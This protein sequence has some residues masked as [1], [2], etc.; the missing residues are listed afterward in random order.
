MTPV[1]LD[2]SLKF[3]FLRMETIAVF[4]DNVELGYCHH[5]H[6]RTHKQTVLGHNMQESIQDLS[7]LV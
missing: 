3:L 2:E 6:A 5:T 1:V 4:I 7:F